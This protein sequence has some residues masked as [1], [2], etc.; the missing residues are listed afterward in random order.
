M[1][2]LLSSLFRCLKPKAKPK[3]KP[4]EDIPEFFLAP[5]GRVSPRNLMPGRVQISL[6][7]PPKDHKAL[8]RFEDS[9]GRLLNLS[10]TNSTTPELMLK[11]IT[12]A[13][14]HSTRIARAKSLMRYK[15]ED[16]NYAPIGASKDD[17]LKDY[18]EMLAV[19]DNLEVAK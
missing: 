4:V 14:K 18:I 13:S 7:L 10:V 12:W 16:F 5:F 8:R 9:V 17:I 11:Y 19:V 6:P 3:P 2:K 1:S 15:S